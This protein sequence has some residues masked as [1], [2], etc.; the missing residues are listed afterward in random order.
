[1]SSRRVGQRFQEDIETSCQEQNVFF[2]N[3]RD[4]FLP[5]DVRRRVSLPKNKYDTL[6]YH[7]GYLFPTELKTTKGKS[8]PFEAIKDHQVENLKKDTDNFQGV[9]AGLLLN[10]RE[11]PENLTYFIHIND[12]I[13]YMFYA[14]NQLPH[15]Y[16]C[17]EG[18]KIN[19]KSISLDICQEIG[20]ELHSEIKRVRY[21][22]FIKE[23]LEEIISIYK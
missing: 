9:T 1:M 22:Y 4:V 17:R 23:L 11:Q 7:N 3:I 10:F 18:R 14:E 2:H 6:L 15:K 20:I 8:I 12:Y 16:K 19:R 5:A 13:D 21:R